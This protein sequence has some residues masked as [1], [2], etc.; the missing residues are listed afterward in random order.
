MY[1]SLTPSAVQIDPNQDP[2]WD[3]HSLLMA[4]SPT[5]LLGTLPP[6]FQMKFIFLHFNYFISNNNVILFVSWI[7]NIMFSWFCIFFFLS[8]VFFSYFYCFYCVIMYE[9]FIT[10]SNCFSLIKCFF[11]MVW[12]HFWLSSTRLVNWICGL[13]FTKTLKM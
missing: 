2:F 5:I 8:L 12:N 11:K 3:T 4:S 9:W 1:F 10:L 6:Y 7:W 13:C